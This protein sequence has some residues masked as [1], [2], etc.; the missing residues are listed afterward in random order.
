M[1]TNDD[2]KNLDF[3]LPTVLFTDSEYNMGLNKEFKP[4]LTQILYLLNSG[5]RN[6]IVDYGTDYGYFALKYI[7]E[8]QKYYSTNLISMK[9]LGGPAAKGNY[10]HILLETASCDYCLGSITP[11]CY[12]ELLKKCCCIST[13][14]GLIPSRGKIPPFL[15]ERLE[16][17]ENKIE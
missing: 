4:N 5:Y 1:Y 16:A 9:I 6:C 13:P 12:Y 2:I 11:A 8:L 10:P 17:Q 7:K 14:D 3:S 15:L